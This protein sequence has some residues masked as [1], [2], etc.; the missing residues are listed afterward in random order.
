MKKSLLTHIIGELSRVNKMD[1][2]E[3]T[4][5]EVEVY[6]LE[7]ELE[8]ANEV[9]CGVKKCSNYADVRS[10]LSGWDES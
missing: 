7:L 4:R 1:G 6:A 3:I 10:V 9:L 5:L 8:H 2:R